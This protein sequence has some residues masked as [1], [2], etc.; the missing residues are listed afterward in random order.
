MREVKIRCTGFN[1]YFN[2]ENNLLFNRLRKRYKLVIDDNPDFLLYSDWGLGHLRYD[3][4]IKIYWTTEN[5]YPNFGYCDY[6][7]S[8]NYINFEDR[9]FRHRWS[10]VKILMNTLII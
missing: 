1:R 10:V 2:S 6:A 7:V 8:F 3:N 5:T 4:C 9:H